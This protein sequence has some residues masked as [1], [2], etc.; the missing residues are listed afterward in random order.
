MLSPSTTS[1]K[2]HA[3]T[4]IEGESSSDRARLPPECRFV[5]VRS[6]KNCPPKCC[7]GSTAGYGHDTLKSTK[8]PSSLSAVIICDDLLAPAPPKLP[9]ISSSNWWNISHG[10]RGRARTVKGGQAEELPTSSRCCTMRYSDVMMLGMRP[11]TRRVRPS[12][13]LVWRAVSGSGVQ[14][15]F[16]QRQL[17]SARLR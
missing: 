5:P 14:Q 2:H 4:G 6:R 1:T 16:Q 3:G 13:S 15:C 8:T 17:R 10:I 7:S 9:P 12:H 11:V